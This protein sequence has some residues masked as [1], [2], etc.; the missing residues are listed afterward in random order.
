M[1]AV[2]CI[3]QV[4][5]SILI[6]IDP[7]TNTLIREWLA[8]GVDRA[9]FLSNHIFGSATPCLRAT[10]WQQRCANLRAKK[11]SVDKFFAKDFLT[12]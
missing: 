1:Q 11:R 8:L 10:F 12:V 2:A 5:D 3:K 7:V 4:P 6:Q 9:L